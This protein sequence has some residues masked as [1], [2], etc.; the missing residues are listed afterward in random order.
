MVAD[1]Q[2]AHQGTITNLKATKVRRL[3]DGSLFGT[4]GSVTF[5]CR[6]VEWLNDGGELPVLKEPDDGFIALLLK[7]SGGLFLMGQDGHPSEIQAPYAVGSGMDIA[8][9]AMRAGA[10]PTRAVEIAAECD[11]HTGGEIT[12][13]ALATAE[14][15]E[16][17]REA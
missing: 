13:L 3:N 4:T 17:R 10:S 1:G 14:I 2:R 8:I 16:L 6:M 15:T 5:G 7:P 12:E 11:P 9:G